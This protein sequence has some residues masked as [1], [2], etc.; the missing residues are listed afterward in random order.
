MAT[1][2]EDRLA[3][4]GIIE[5]VGEVAAHKGRGG[6]LQIVHEPGKV[7]VSRTP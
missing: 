1:G 6:R 5:L 3:A 7:E 2:P 4:M